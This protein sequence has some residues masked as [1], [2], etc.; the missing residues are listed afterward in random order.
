MNQRSCCPPGGEAYQ[1][2][3]IP[4]V[5]QLV[6]RVAKRLKQMQRE[7][8]AGV[9]LTPP[10]YFVLGQLWARDSR[11]LGELAEASY[12]TPATMTGIVD[13]LEGKDL[14]C[15][16]PNPEDRRSL[17]VTLTAAGRAMEASAPTPAAIFG[18]CCD[19]L[20]PEEARHL[21]ALLRKLLVS[22]DGC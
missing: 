12:C 17:L 8:V 1:D 22:L 15:R 13:T 20:A 21:S 5:F 19:G 16:V 4:E 18:N 9:G 11:P 10:Q 2:G 3:S 14:I 7:T 6:E